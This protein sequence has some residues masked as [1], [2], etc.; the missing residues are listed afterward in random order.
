[1]APEVER[2]SRLIGE[3][4]DAALD[5]SRWYDT[6]RNLAG[7]VGGSGSTLYFTNT[8]RLTGASQ[9]DWGIDPSFK[10]SYFD[11]YIKFDPT[12]PARFMF[13]VEQVYST[14]DI[15][16]YDEFLETRFYKEWGKPQSMI[17]MIQATLDKTATSFSACGVILGEKEGPANGETY[18]RMRLVVPHIRRAALIGN[19]IDLRKSEAAQFA[20][21]LD[22]LSAGMFLVDETGRIVHAN[23][24][25]QAMLA[26]A[27]VLRSP[28]GRL[29]TNESSIERGLYDVFAAAA[30]G[31]EAVGTRGIAVPLMARDGER[32]V[33]HVLP[34][35]SGARRRTGADYAAVAAVFVHRAALDTPSPPEIIAKT[36]KL[37]PAELR[38]LLAIV[39]IGGVPEVAA[40]LGIA[41]TTVKTHLGRVFEKTGTGRQADLVKLVAEFSNPLLN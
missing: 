22:G 16:P 2:L 35:T 11:T 9:Y 21:T 41:D 3:I 10:Q 36:F 37:T 31:D 17:D 23:A 34:L 33:A 32:Y 19:A 15:V 27:S 12:T 28:E 38:V 1:M 26:E 24:S 20:D 8:L 14:V 30:G 40:A 39:N 4:Y 13:D 25:G 29:T 5:P 7:F 18:R 6:L